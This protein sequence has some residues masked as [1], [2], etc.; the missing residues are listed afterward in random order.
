MRGIESYCKVYNI[1]KHQIKEIVSFLQKPGLSKRVVGDFLGEKDD[2][3]QKILQ[4][5]LNDINFS[6][7]EFDDALR[8]FLSHFRLPGEAQKIDRIMEKFAARYLE[9]NKNIFADPDTAYILAFS[10]IMLNTDAHNPSIKKEEKMTKQQFVNN[11]RGINKNEN[12]PTE[13]LEKLYDGIYE[14]EIQSDFERE[15]FIQWDFQG[16]LQVQEVGDG[17]FVKKKSWKRL[18]CIITGHTLFIFEYPTDASPYLILP[19]QEDRNFT[20]SDISEKPNGFQIS[21]PNGSLKGAKS[22]KQVFLTSINFEADT[23]NQK[24]QWIYILKYATSYQTK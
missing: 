9:C 1:S 15:E 8:L 24:V 7:V 6:N 2:F 5:M 14:N 21:N 3:N 23:N 4:E 13:Y 20:I 10:L 16:F 18:W 22:G 17:P 11:N 19:L 12:L